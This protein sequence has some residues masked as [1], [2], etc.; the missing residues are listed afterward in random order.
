MWIRSQ[1]QENYL[2]A[3]GKTFSIYNGNQIRMKYANSSVLL[4]EYSSSK[5]AHNVLNKLRKQK[6][7]LYEKLNK[8]Q[9]LQSIFE[10]AR[11]FDFYRKYGK[12]VRIAVSGLLT[13]G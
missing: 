4:G 2:D 13:N 12:M 6:E 9:K 5:K 8:V 11:G 10:A 1:N 7:R 3:S